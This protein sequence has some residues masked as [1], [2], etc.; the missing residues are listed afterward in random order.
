MQMF[1]DGKYILFVLIS[2]PIHCETMHK[3]TSI[4]YTL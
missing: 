4:I 3:I 1:P 2:N